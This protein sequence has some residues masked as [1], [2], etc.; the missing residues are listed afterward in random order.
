[1]YHGIVLNE[2]FK[3]QKFPE[4]LN[5]FAK[6]ESSDNSWVLYGIEIDDDRLEAVVGDI[7]KNMTDA[8]PYYAHLYNNQEL[9]VIFKT[10]IFKAT[11]D[12]ATWGEIRNYGSALGIPVE[13][14]DFWPNRFQDERHYF[15]PKDYVKR[16]TDGSQGLRS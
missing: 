2:E 9:I 1:M 3:D 5:V 14:L 12:E 10:K 16:E 6:R 11:P 15:E 8:D 4:S 7:Q 13:Q